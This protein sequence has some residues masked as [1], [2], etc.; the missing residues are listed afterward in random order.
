MEPKFSSAHKHTHHQRISAIRQYLSTGAAPF[1]PDFQRVTEKLPKLQTAQ[2][3]LFKYFSD[4]FCGYVHFQWEGDAAAM[5]WYLYFVTLYVH[6]RYLFCNKC[7][8]PAL[9][10]EGS[11]DICIHEHNNDYY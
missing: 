4:F 1:L 11:R 5:V 3:V 9:S 2:L 8:H 10:E 7:E 6:S